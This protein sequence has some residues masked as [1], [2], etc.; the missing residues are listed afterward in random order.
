MKK[1][2]DGW[3]LPPGGS[4]AFPI[5]VRKAVGYQLTKFSMEFKPDDWKNRFQ[6]LAGANE[7]RF[8]TTMVFIALC[9]S[10]VW[11]KLPY[12]L[13]SFQNR[14]KQNQSAR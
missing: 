13:H 14:R 2:F 7:I 10:A 6:K 9:M 3:D 12:V 8:V 1:K 5:T 4:P 11:K